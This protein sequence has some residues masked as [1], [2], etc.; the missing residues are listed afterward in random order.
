VN[1]QERD[2]EF[3]WLKDLTD[4]QIFKIW[5]TYDRVYD[6]EASFFDHPITR[7]EVIDL[8]GSLL[9]PTISADQM[10]YLEDQLE[11]DEEYKLANWIRKLRH[12]RESAEEERLRYER[13]DELAERLARQRRRRKPRN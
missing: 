9:D 6:H 12:E 13:D 7:A 3:P 10:E 5:L 8:V 4:E 11:F 2:E 1:Q